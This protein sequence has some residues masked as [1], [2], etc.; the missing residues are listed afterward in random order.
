MA[1]TTPDIRNKVMLIGLDG[2][3]FYLLKP[4]MEDG[5]L[6][7]LAS[8]VK[9]SSSS[10]LESTVPCTT[11]PAWSSCVTGKNPGKHGI[12][13]F[14]ESPHM[15][16][17][18]PLITASSV[19]ARKV[20][21]ILNEKGC[22]VVV[23]NV[24]ITFPPEPVDGVMISGLMTPSL[25]SEF[26]YPAS[27]KAE[28][29]TRIGDYIPNIDIPKYDVELKD[30]AIGFLDELS[31]SFKK[32]VDAF[33]YLKDNKPWEFLM[34]VFIVP[35]RIQH[36]FWKFIDPACSL[37]ESKMGEFIRPRVKQCFIEMDS[38]FGRLLEEISDDTALL[39]MSDHGFGSTHAWINMNTYLEK[40]GLLRLKGMEKVK[41]QLFFQA[42]LANDSAF[43]KRVVPL[44]LQGTIRRKVR[45]TRST[46]K[47]DVE[48]SLDWEHTKAFFPSIPG[49]GVFLNLGSGDRKG[50]V[51]PGKE[52]ENLRETIKQSLLELRD[53]ESGE[54]IMDWV[55]FRE[56]LYTGGQV[57]Y[58][59]DVVFCAR[60]YSF[61]ARQHFGD[62]RVIR[63]SENAP[64]GFP[65]P[66]GVF[67][68]RG[69]EIK[70][71]F[72]FT[73][74]DIMDLTPTVLYLMGYPV[75]DDMDGRVLTEILKDGIT[76]TYPVQTEPAGAFEEDSRRDYTEEEEEKIRT[77]LKALGY[78][79]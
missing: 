41:K 35:D 40:L 17:R 27:L 1:E 15:D 9:E 54:T 43:V 79:E 28:L 74:A 60:N 22:K 49:Q 12:F 5:S 4:W 37:Y 26:M 61:L 29:G 51:Q 50:T 18:R 16:P 36:L 44:S 6:P 78:I 32:R 68:A 7:H 71:G 23:M 64:N 13:D 67:I 69:K 10:D 11:P 38:F 14:R 39:I 76:D 55:K 19:K 72:T 65:R 48:A 66:E 52:Y 77:R 56:E 63:L 21:H 2:A 3:T 73:G 42:V 62:P 20:W 24:P 46:F 34:T 33:F 47:T 30:D 53:P 75:P 58:A 45:G 8:L 31:Y 25:D 59:P 70:E 57:K